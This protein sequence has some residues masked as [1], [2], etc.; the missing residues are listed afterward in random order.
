MQNILCIV[1]GKIKNMQTYVFFLDLF[2]R[3]Y[4]Y[5]WKLI[6]GFEAVVEKKTFAFHFIHFALF[7]KFNIHKDNVCFQVFTTVGPAQHAQK[8]SHLTPNPALF[9][10]LTT[11]DNSPILQ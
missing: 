11:L 5:N 2:T 3:K 7:E 8:S 4:D 9:F 6:Q 1:M 10:V